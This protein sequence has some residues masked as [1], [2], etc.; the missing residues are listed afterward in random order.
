M[1][2]GIDGRTDTAAMDKAKDEFLS[3][4]GFERDPSRPELGHV[5]TPPSAEKILGFCQM[6]CYT[7]IRPK[8]K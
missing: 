5:I 2:A 8:G 6:D 1:A 4:H 3:A 7:P